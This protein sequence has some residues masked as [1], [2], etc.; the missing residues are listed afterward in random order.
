MARPAKSTAVISKNLTAEELAARRKIEEKTKGK[1]DCIR[2][3]TYLTT[4]QKKIFKNIVK[5]LEN[6]NILGN[7]DVYILSQC[8]ISIDR[9][10]YIEKRLNTEPQLLFETAFMS[11]KDKYTKDFF[12][13]CNELCL[14]PQSRAK[15]ANLN[16]QAKEEDPLKKALQSND[17]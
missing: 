9:I 14:S 5:E 1:S 15:L 4:A 13:C 17:D 11:S 6:S 2:P 12:R 16:V 7:L 8:A 10:Q 3:P